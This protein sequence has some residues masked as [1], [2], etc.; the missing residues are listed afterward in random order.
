MTTDQPVPSRL[1]LG[2]DLG[3]VTDYSALAIAEERA[4]LVE[5]GV[6]REPP[7][8]RW[9]DPPDY[10]VPWLQRW[11]L[12]TPYH[13][14]AA[15]VGALVTT[16]AARR[17]RPVLALYVDGTGV[18]TAVVEL[19]ARQ[20]ALGAIL[21]A[22]TITAGNGAIRVP[23][24]WHVGKS[25]LVATAQV[26]LQ[27]GRLKVAAGL[28]EAATLVAELRGFE[29]K[30]TEAANQVFRHREGEHD[31]LLLAVALALWGAARPVRSIP[32]PPPAVAVPRD[33]PA[34]LHGWLR[35][36]GARER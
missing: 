33:A 2:L 34:P 15:E 24:G 29:V 22:V 8:P 18:G 10:A 13:A 11:P 3:K 14:I 7:R 9:P 20:P 16:L 6:P 27:G 5:S 35:T 4:L 26:A 19:L 36:G 31:D 1:T 32:P 30:Y 21:Q 25:E 28:P 23:G 12:Q 17:P